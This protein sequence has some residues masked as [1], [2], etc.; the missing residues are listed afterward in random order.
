MNAIRRR[1]GFAGTLQQFFAHIRDG[2]QFYYPNTAAGKQPYLDESIKAEA[3]VA[4]ALPRFSGG[5]PSRSC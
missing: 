1:V 3:Q 5:C 2:K 4:A